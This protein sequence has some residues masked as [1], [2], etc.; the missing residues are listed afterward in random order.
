[1]SNL[2]QW[3][4]FCSRP[5]GHS[6]DGKAGAARVQGIVVARHKRRVAELNGAMEGPSM[7]LVHIDLRSYTVQCDPERPLT[8]PATRREAHRNQEHSAPSSWRVGVVSAVAP[9]LALGVDVHPS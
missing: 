7:H 6:A 5:S 9:L 2:S 8:K 1:M 3:L 4:Q